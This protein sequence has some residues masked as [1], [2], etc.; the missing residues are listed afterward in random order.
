MTN[1]KSFEEGSIVAT[2]GCLIDQ[3]GSSKKSSMLCEVIASGEKDILVKEI[4]SSMY[5]S[6]FKIPKSLCTKI[7]F[8]IAKIES[9]RIMKPS[10]G[11]LVLSYTKGKFSTESDTS[12]TGIVY[13]IIYSQGRP[14][15]CTLL[16]DGE[17]KSVDYTSLMVLQSN[18]EK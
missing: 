7:D 10:L 3:S 6:I 12:I 11:D 17:M 18:I 5:P 16:C 14:K 9:D 1:E 15:K 13:E 2:T 8:D 4:T